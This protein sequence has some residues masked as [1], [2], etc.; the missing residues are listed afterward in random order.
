[1]IPRGYL[2]MFKCKWTSLFFFVHC[3]SHVFDSSAGAII[4]RIAYGYTIEPP[5]FTKGNAA[6][7]YSGGTYSGPE[8]PL[9]ELADRGIAQI[10][11]AA[12]PGNFLVDV[13]P[14]RECCFLFFFPSSVRPFGWR[15][16][17]CD[18]KL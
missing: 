16:K 18:W 9:V 17:R 13:L 11:Y 1:M 14:F 10:S 7:G 3:Q 8:D 5:A 4:L 15:K 2:S 12:Q 6:K